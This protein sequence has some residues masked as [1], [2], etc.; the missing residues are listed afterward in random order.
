MDYQ[1]IIAL[2]ALVVGGYGTYLQHVQTKMMLSKTSSRKT[3]VTILSL[4]K[5]PQTLVL[6]FLV[7]L[8][9][10]PWMLTLWTSRQINNDGSDAAAVV[11]WGGAGRPGLFHVTANG[12]HLLPYESEYKLLAFSTFYDGTQNPQ[13]VEFFKKSSVYDIMSGN[14]HMGML[15][16]EDELKTKRGALNFGLSMIPNGLNPGSFS[17][18]NEAQALGA[19]FIWKGAVN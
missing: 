10:V 1:L 9:W 5:S 13:D 18:V 11:G 14:I 2:I 12:S 3:Q 16:D 8:V 7:A 15:F 17:T 4:W 6:V 19:K